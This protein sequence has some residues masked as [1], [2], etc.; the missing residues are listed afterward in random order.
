MKIALLDDEQFHLDQL[1]KALLDYDSTFI[2]ETFL[3]AKLLLMS[4]ESFDL[5]FMDI[6]MPQISGVELAQTYMGRFPHVIFV[7]SHDERVYD[8]FY[9]NIIG[10]VCKRDLQ[11]KL[12]P[13]LE[14]AIRLMKQTITLPINQE[15]IEM[16]ENDIIYFFIEYHRIYV[17]T[18]KKRIQLNLKSLKELDRSENFFMINRKVIVNL[19]H[20]MNFYRQTHEISVTN[21]DKLSVSKRNWSE[22]LKQ[23]R[24]VSLM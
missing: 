18:T 5:V 24:K 11:E 17:Q 12:I 1:K 2:I 20:V 19:S 8:A 13:A 22:F 6:E 3:T 4:E 10:F 16:E 21:N 9:P 7:S 14:K 15:L 23:Y